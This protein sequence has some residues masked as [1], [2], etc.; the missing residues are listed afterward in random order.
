M[1]LGIAGRVALVAASSR[2]LGLACAERLAQEGCHVALCGRD[3]AALAAAVARVRAKSLSGRVVGHRADL[4]EASAIDALVAAVTADLGGIDILVVNS[5]GPPPGTFDAADDAKWIAAYHLVF[6]SAVRLIR[7]VLPGMK[8]RGWGR[9]VCIASRAVRE[10][11]PNLIIS[12]AVRL[13][14]A[15]MTKTLSAE[16]AAHGV[17]VNT[18]GP[19]PTATDRALELAGA[20]AAKRG[21][22]V[23]EELAQT[24]ASIPAGRLATPDELAAAVA[25]L[26]SEPARH[27]TGVSLLVDGGASRGL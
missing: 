14:L 8:E 24:A 15:G 9:V 3:E 6:L 18:V 12:N 20:R 10:P 22:S 7:T 19:G 26:A 2:G 11:I 27:I 16:V 5:G 23:E 1:D 4:T 17:T 21:V 13:G 25:F